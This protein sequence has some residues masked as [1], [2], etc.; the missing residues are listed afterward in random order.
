M[1]FFGVLLL[2]AGTSFA[3][4]FTTGQAARLVIG[5]T[6]FTAQASGASDTLVGGVGG[7]AFAQD[8]LFVTDANRVAAAPINHRVL[9]F[10]NLSGTLP[11]PTDRLEW[12]RECPV[13]LGTASVVLGQKDFTETAFTFPPVAKGFRTPT[14]VASDGVRLAVA[15]TDNNR[16]LIW[17]SIPINNQAEPNVVLGQPDFNSSSV[18]QPPT[19]KSLRGPQGVWIQDGRL[20]VADTVNNRVLIWNSIPTSNG[21]AADVVVGQPDFGV[22][23]QLDLTKAVFDPK[24]DSL[25][26]P[27]SVTSD[28]QRLYV[29]DLGHN[30][31]LI[32]NSIPTQNHRPADVVIGQ[33]DMTSA[34]PNNV[35]KLCASNGTDADGNPTYPRLCSTTMDFPRFALSDGRRLFI[36]DGGNDRVLV[37]NS[38]PTAN[39][40]AADVVL[41]QPTMELNLGSDQGYPLRS[42][43]ADSLR[44]PLSMAWD[45]LNLFVSDSFNRRI[46]V[47]TMAEKAIPFAGVRNSASRAIHAVGGFNVEG[48]I[49]ADDQVTLTIGGKD[50]VYK[51]VAKDTLESIA[52]S[53]VGLINAGEGD[54]LV[55]G[56][57]NTGTG[58]VQLILT[59]RA[60]GAEGDSVTIAG[61]TSDSAK[62]FVTAMG[63]NLAGGKDAF[64]IGPGTLVMIVGENLA[65]QTAAA[66]PDSEVLPD[67]LG[68]AEVYLNGIR[69]PL[70]FVSPTQINAQVPFELNNTTSINAFVR[71]QWRDGRLTATNPVSVTVVP[72]NPGIFSYEGTEPRAAVALHYSSHATGTVSVDG[73]VFPGE[74]ATVVIRDREYTYTVMEGDTLNSIRDALV[75]LV[76]QDPEVEASPS[77]IFTRIRL[78]ARIEGPEGNGIQFSVKTTDA[79]S[80]LLSPFNV[81]LCCAN[82]AGSLVTEDNPALPGETILIYATGLGA[83][84]PDEARQATLTGRRYSGPALN[85]PDEFVSS[86]LNGKTANVL[87][88]GLAP[89]W[90]G[91][92]E[93]HLELN[94]GQFTNPRSQLTIA[95]SEFVS[96]IV[97]VPVFN[98]NPTAE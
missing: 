95:Q 91:V 61:K 8:T 25:L 66:S 88:A 75:A 50:Y 38:V 96:N 62:I 59:A 82:E 58:L 3:A 84:K 72:Q 94:S 76:N 92:Y 34:A 19:A 56:S 51:V 45:G 49:N 10:K 31:V 90:I 57:A 77:A 70:L 43:A 41:G 21:Q 85:D 80:V 6:T 73:S 9:L 30:R 32:W 22:V 15:D 97:T 37:Y 64:K 36:A 40:Q 2:A 63:A 4:E 5:Q 42:S 54:P 24:P 39:A 86:L 69:A 98:P 65:D 11:N 18:A 53:F 1:K 79:A 26:N 12:T 67:T 89:G 52:E 81:S 78:K 27:V 55:Y 74:T 35:T 93:V 83:V 28:G 44:T 71:V 16:V 17:N 68:G 46:M 87:S 20:F 33:P 13:C 48:T 60:E 47:F 23:V 29:A 7:L 14:A